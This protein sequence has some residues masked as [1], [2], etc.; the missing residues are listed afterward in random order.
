MNKI[1]TICVLSLLALSACSKDAP[2]ADEPYYDR[3]KEASKDAH[4][5]L[6]ND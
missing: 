6:R 5:Q 4:S 3:A 1:F 2:K